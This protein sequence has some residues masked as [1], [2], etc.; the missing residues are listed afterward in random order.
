MLNFGSQ[1][2]LARLLA[3][4][5]VTVQHGNFRTAFFDVNN[6]VLGLPLWKNFGKDV[7]DLLVGHEVGHALYT[8]ADGWHNVES[9]LPNVPK[10]YLNVVEDIRIEKKIQRTYPGL[11]GSFK[12]GYKYLNEIDFFDI[13]DR[14]VNRMSLM[15][16]I[17][18]KSKLRDLIDVQFTASEMPLVQQA[19]SVETWDDVLKACK[20]LYDYIEQHKDEYAEEQ[21][22][23]DV[24]STSDEADEF[25]P[26]NGGENP[27][28]VESSPSVDKPSDSSTDVPDNSSEK[29]DSTNQKVT[30]PTEGNDPHEVSTDDAFRRN[31]ST[32][33]EIDNR[34]Y[35]PKYIRAIT[36]AQAEQ[37]IVPYKNIIRDRNA[38]IASGTRSAP[39]DD[40][41]ERF[42]KFNETTKKFVNLMS[43]EFEMRKMAYRY[44]RSQT[45][46]SGTLNV[47]KLYSYKYNDD[48]FNRVTKLADAKSH[49]MV[50]IIDYSGSMD[51]ILSDV[52]H[53]TLILATFCKKVNIP[54]EVYSFTSGYGDR[55]IGRYDVAPDKLYDKL[56]DGTVYAYGTQILQLLTS[57][58]NKSDYTRC[59]K[60]L[61]MQAYERSNRYA[62]TGS[63]N[64]FYE[65]L[66]GTPLNETIMAS[67]FILEDF[68]KKHGVQK[69]NAI[70]LTDGD[71]QSFHLVQRNDL[72]KNSIR[73][74]GYIVDVDGT[75]L[76]CKSGKSEMTEQLLNDLRKKY[77]V[78]G[79]FLS[80]NGHDMKGKVWEA[81]EKFVPDSEMNKIRKAYNDNK[82]VSYDDVMGYD[83][84]FIIKAE[85]QSLD[86]DDDGFEVD[87]EA[88]KSQIQRAFMKHTSSKK[89]NK[90][91]ATQFAEMVS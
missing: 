34:G 21:L 11:I 55:T 66:S 46:R 15:D 74:N 80:T 69:V 62:V 45:A 54:F 28:E 3:K 38:R 24:Q 57:S 73:T 17:N 91:F 25:D 65:S 77:T 52:I 58:M 42:V 81:S 1:S 33:L 2:A 83:R 40:R 18:L 20:D 61:F 36:R 72:D 16:R 39:A 53:Q 86:V 87:T 68:Q 71:G 29:Q 76:E 63:H 4:E 44:S 9:V 70:F 5:N 32:L 22:S 7:Y 60:D 49:G 59:F 8:P 51:R 19:L 89:A 41:E 67:R 14:D 64:A 88:S 10:S 30:E 13:K 56:I 78:I 27:T 26:S 31:E 35:Q 84:F 47:D 85:K 50:M 79:Y 37:I 48:I 75:L 12:R 43:K 82:F 23:I 90:L 6:R